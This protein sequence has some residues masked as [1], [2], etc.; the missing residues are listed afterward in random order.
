MPAAAYA[1]EAVEHYRTI[2]H[3]KCG[4]SPTK[5]FPVPPSGFCGKLGHDVWIRDVLEWT[6]PQS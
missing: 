2:L 4:S 3:V 6:T 5:T 1:A